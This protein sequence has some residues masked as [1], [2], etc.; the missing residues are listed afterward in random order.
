VV[1]EQAI[2]FCTAPDGVRLAWAQNGSGP[3][4]VKA[5]NWLTHLEFDWE[6]SVWRHWLEGLGE[7][8]TLVRYDER[9]CGLSD[10]EAKELSLDR[11][12]ADLETVIDAA[13]L[14]RFVLLGVSQGAAT[15]IAY[16]V[17]HPDRVDRLVLYGGYARGRGRRG[18][19][20]RERLD[21]FL[22]AIRT[23]WTDP[24]PTFRHLFTML[25]LPQGSPEQMAWY[26]ELQRRSTS[27]ENA[28]R[29]YR[30][31]AEVDVSDL[32]SRVAAKALVAHARGDR[33]VPF[34][35]GRILASLLP[36]AKL[37]PLESVNHILLRDEP[38]WTAF[39]AEV[40]AFLGASVPTMPAELSALSNRELEVL[41]LVAAGLSNDE[42]ASRL[43]VSVRTV[44]RHLSNTYVKLRVS[45]RAGR[46]A[47]AA[48]FARLRESSPLRG[49]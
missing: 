47:A 34:E 27:A 5:A 23:G 26:D 17:R 13:G 39:L 25:F 8:H 37:V 44:E 38:A 40:H 32:A 18:E 49:T 11:W 29:L 45:G 10:R 41:E 14:D 42:I 21:A 6:S 12:V 2:R 19:Q 20:Q 48:R 4:L 33:V 28:V 43:Y 9:G 7:R 36:T 24:D 16:T 35:E 1:V 15:A 3:P 46:A 22:S 31:R 30:A